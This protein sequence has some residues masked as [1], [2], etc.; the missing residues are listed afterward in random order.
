[1]TLYRVGR[2]LR[3]GVFGLGEVLPYVFTKEV[4]HRLRTLGFHYK[5]PEWK[6][7]SLRAYPIVRS[8]V[9][10][11]VDVKMGSQRYQLFKAKGTTCVKCG[12]KGT[13]FALERGLV[14]NPDRFHFNLYARDRRGLEVMLTK[15][16][17]I[18]R[19][20]GGKNR[21]RNYQPMCSKCNSKKAD[22]L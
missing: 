12:I 11:T 8:G 9:V 22:N 14:D 2:Y 21:L 5:S 10:H 6:A 18:P 1:M 3:A 17:I 13:Y 4:R 7:A 16:H 20:K 15:D 19:S